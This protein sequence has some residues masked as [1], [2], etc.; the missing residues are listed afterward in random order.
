MVI[1]HR[2]D[3]GSLRLF[4]RIR[5]STTEGIGDFTIG[6]IEGILRDLQSSRNDLQQRINQ[7]TPNSQNQLIPQLTQTDKE[8]LY[9]TEVISVYNNGGNYDSTSYRQSIVDDFSVFDSKFTIPYTIEWDTD[10]VLQLPLRNSI[11]GSDLGEIQNNTNSGIRNG[12]QMDDRWIVSSSV[13]I[14]PNIPFPTILQT[15]RV[16]GVLTDFNYLPTPSPSQPPLINTQTYEFEGM[17]SEVNGNRKNPPT[18]E[19]IYNVEY[20]Y[21]GSNQ[22]TLLLTHQTDV[23]GGNPSFSNDLLVDGVSVIENQ[24]TFVI[25]GCNVSTSLTLDVLPIPPNNISVGR[26]FRDNDLQRVIYLPQFVG[27]QSV[28]TQYD[29]I[30]PNIDVDIRYEIDRFIGYPLNITITEVGN[31]PQIPSTQRV[32]LDGLDIPPLTPNIY[33]RENGD[34]V[35]ESTSTLT[36]FDTTTMISFEIMVDGVIVDF[37]SIQQNPNMNVSQTLM[38]TIP[39]VNQSHSVEFIYRYF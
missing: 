7:L 34:V 13:E 1:L 23:L 9:Y 12:F 30:F 21:S 14:S 35:L 15:L 32:D 3:D 4:D 22:P 29:F 6:E 11:S 38:Y 20:G 2:F 28:S 36:P 24:S 16:N 19:T 8:I 37:T 26:I 10:N 27:N 18:N 25:Q 33:V 31:P 17:I 39:N 5:F